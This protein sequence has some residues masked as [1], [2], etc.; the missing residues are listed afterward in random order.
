MAL[1][2]EAVKETSRWH[3]K[4]PPAERT[5]GSL[6]AERRETEE[7]REREREEREMRERDEKEMR[8][9]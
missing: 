1:F 2:L 3:R 7:R 6:R 8:E 4:D 5:V 9:R